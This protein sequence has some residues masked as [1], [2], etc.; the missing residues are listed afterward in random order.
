M[1]K[2]MQEEDG[3]DHEKRLVKPEKYCRGCSGYNERVNPQHILGKQP[4]VHPEGIREKS[5]GEGGHFPEHRFSPPGQPI[6]H[7]QNFL[8]VMKHEDNREKPQYAYQLHPCVYGRKQV[9]AA[10]IR[11]SPSPCSFRPY[12]LPKA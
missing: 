10:Q 8:E 6:F 3:Q 1:R 7:R 2:H 5:P 9:S 12:V 11:S 4:R